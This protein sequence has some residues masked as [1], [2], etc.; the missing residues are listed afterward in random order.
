MTRKQVQEQTSKLSIT[1]TLSCQSSSGAIV[2]GEIAQELRKLVIKNFKRS[3]VYARFKDVWA[4]DL[5]E[6]GFLSSFNHGDKYLLRVIDVF[7]KYTWVKPLIDKT[8]LHG[9]TEIVNK[10]KHKSNKL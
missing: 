5:V 6:M 1:I 3:K 8:A 10:S 4:A 7:T 2:N 9:F